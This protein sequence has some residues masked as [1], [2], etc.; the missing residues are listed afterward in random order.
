MLQIHIG[1][2]EAAVVLVLMQVAAVLTF[3]WAAPP[4]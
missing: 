2:G 4:R 3:A 1:H